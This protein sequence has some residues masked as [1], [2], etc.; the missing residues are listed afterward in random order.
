M[1]SSDLQLLQVS[2]KSF[3]NLKNLINYV[4]CK[5]DLSNFFLEISALGEYKHIFFSF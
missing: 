1:V 5:N 2:Y 4:R 3:T